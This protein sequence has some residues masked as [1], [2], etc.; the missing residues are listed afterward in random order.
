[1]PRHAQPPQRAA[2]QRSG[3]GERFGNAWPAGVLFGSRATGWL[4]ENLPAVLRAGSAAPHLHCFAALGVATRLACRQRDPG[5]RRNATPTVFL[6]DDLRNRP[7]IARPT[8]WRAK[9]ALP[10]AATTILSPNRSLAPD[11][12][13]SANPLPAQLLRSHG[14]P[15]AFSAS[16]FW[17]NM[18]SNQTRT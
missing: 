7:T 16:V 1:M 6:G 12:Q 8:G 2:R 13:P 15:T 4:W 18:S 17:L 3:G 5:R 10:R 9:L 11:T 14:V